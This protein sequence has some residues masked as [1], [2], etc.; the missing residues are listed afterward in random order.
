MGDR[1]TTKLSLCYEGKREC[2]EG[3]A[4]SQLEALEK[5]QRQRLTWSLMEEQTLQIKQ[6]GN[7]GRGHGEARVVKRATTLLHSGWTSA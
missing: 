4:S 1:V 3:T 6:K 2:R 7:T 5:L